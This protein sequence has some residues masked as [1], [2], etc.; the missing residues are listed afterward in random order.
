MMIKRRQRESLICAKKWNEKPENT[1]KNQT[2]VS[3]FASH[4]YHSFNNNSK[5]SNCIGAV[6]IIGGCN[7]VVFFKYL[8]HDIQPR[9][10]FD[11]QCSL[12]LAFA[13]TLIDDL[14]RHSH[15]MH[16]HFVVLCSTK[17]VP[18][19]NSHQHSCSRIPILYM[20][21]WKCWNITSNC[22]IALIANIRISSECTT[23]VTL[24]T[25]SVSKFPFDCRIKMVRK[26]LSTFQLSRNMNVFFI[27]HDELSCGARQSNTQKYKNEKYSCGKNVCLTS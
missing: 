25:L 19:K 2:N 15:A 20:Y 1:G 7:K 8:H 18:I 21:T 23:C 27:S 26:L 16:N 13:F 22:L 24:F 11:F 12:A 5:K 17:S 9:G 3:W 4:V 14:D 10:S 6:I